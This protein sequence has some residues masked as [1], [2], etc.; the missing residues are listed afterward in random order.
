MTKKCPVC[1]LLFNARRESQN[2]CSERCSKAYYRIR[3]TSSPQE[4]PEK[5]KR[6][7]IGSL[8]KMAAQARNAGMTY[9]QYQQIRYMQEYGEDREKLREMQPVYVKSTG[10]YM[11]RSCGAELEKHRNCQICGKVIIWKA[12]E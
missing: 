12:G 9:G 3:V 11:C 5:K 8:N 4:K 10:K 2:T 6:D 1:K 7:E